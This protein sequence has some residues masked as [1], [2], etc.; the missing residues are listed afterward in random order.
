MAAERTVMADYRMNGPTNMN[1]MIM[2]NQKQKDLLITVLRL[3]S[4][5]LG[6]IM[7]RKRKRGNGKITSICYSIAGIRT[8][9]S[10]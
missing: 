5:L 1:T 6:L 2:V 10:W 9:N 3:V 4:G 8:A 7:A